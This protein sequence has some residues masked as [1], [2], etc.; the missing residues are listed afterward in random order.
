[1]S[2]ASELPLR[3][4]HLDFHTSP[5][6]PD[7]GADWDPAD[8]V[9][10]LTEARVQS[11]NI[12]AKC[13][14]GM[15]YFPSEVAP[16]HP[17]LSFDLLGEMITACHGAGI[18]CPIYVSV[19]WDVS[20][21][22]R[23]PE[24]VQVDKEGRLVGGQP[25][26]PTWPWLC[27]N[28]GYADELVALTEELLTRYDCDGLWYDILM[29]HA[30]GCLCSKCLPELVRQGR[31]PQSAADRMAHNQEVVRAF[32]ERTSAVIRAHQPD[33]GIFYN[34]RMGLPLQD[35]LDHVT[36]VEIESLPTGGWGYGFYPLWS[37]FARHLGLPYLGMTGRFHRSWADWGGLKH[38]DAL[39]FECGGILA[40]GGA[41]CIGDQ[42]HPRGR[43]NSAVY[44]VIG[45][46]FR[47]VEA[48]AEYVTGAE[49]VAEVGLLAL[50]PER[51]NMDTMGSGGS[52]EGA[53]KLLLELHQQFDV[54]TP[55]CPDFGAYRVLVI[56]DGGVAT[57]ELAARLRAFVAGGGKLLLSHQ[58]LLDEA[59]GAFLLAEE[60][61]LDYAGP[62]RSNPDY[63][64]LTDPDL[65]SP[66]LQPGFSYCLY[67]G[68][69]SR[70]AA[71]PGVRTLAVAHETYFDRTWEHF[72]SHFFTP[73][74]DEV[75]DYPAITQSESVIYLH[76]PIFAA[77]QQFG[78]VAY[79]ELVGKLLARLLPEPL[80][81]TDAPSTAE[82]ALMRQPQRDLVHLVNYHACRRA[83][84]HIESLET[85]P[86]LHDVTVSLRTTA[87]VAEVFLARSGERLAAK[88]AGEYVTVTVPRVEVHEIVVFA[89]K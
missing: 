86:P 80:V 43:L 18:H 65:H 44:R 47:E 38:P 68:P 67:L 10:Q 17:A 72:S 24:W 32:M 29:V 63:F 37:R 55:R 42:M 16:V 14:H 15:C 79:R 57:P 71:R 87:P 4:I 13:H 50:E 89:G 83:T 6:I 82:V 27:L 73:P 12:F 36:Q 8:F 60:M 41:I 49:P 23:H 1:M 76:G 59:A 21:A 39:R 19:G 58:A 48:V 88:Q 61:G 77:Y 26:E 81:A 3:H 2:F 52:L 5:L 69:A 45:E 56:P 28:T 62:A 64:E 53:A 30:D 11:I 70:V 33:A 74:L 35:E 31:D 22:E 40:T 46:A 78:A 66:V 51:N 34:G 7:V 20:A 84:G 54:L 85:P 9:R 25:F 75:A